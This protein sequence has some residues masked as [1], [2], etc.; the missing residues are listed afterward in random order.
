ML[1]FN[2]VYAEVKPTGS[3]TLLQTFLFHP[4]PLTIN[5]TSHSK[6]IYITFKM[7]GES[8][9]LNTTHVGT[10]QKIHSQKEVNTFTK[11]VLKLDSKNLFPIYI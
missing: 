2:I 8:P 6:I 3:F 11:F 7:L 4:F 10:F 9:F 1:V 5:P